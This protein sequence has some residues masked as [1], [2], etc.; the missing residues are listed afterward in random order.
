MVK[1]ELY[2]LLPRYTDTVGVSIRHAE[3]V[4][5]MNA[6]YL[7]VEVRHAATCALP[8]GGCAW[9]DGGQVASLS[10]GS[11]IPACHSD[12]LIS[13]ILVLICFLI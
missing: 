5:P 8:L 4:L 11:F 10:N 2:H 7:S 12:L 1:T 13:F 6:Y 9:R 3:L